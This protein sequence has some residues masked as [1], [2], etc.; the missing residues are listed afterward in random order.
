MT[1]LKHIPEEPQKMAAEKTTLPLPIF[2]AWF[3]LIFL[4]GHKDLEEVFFPFTWKPDFQCS[5]K[6]GTAFPG[7]TG[8]YCSPG[9]RHLKQV[10]QLLLTPTEA[11]AQRLCR[12]LSFTDSTS[13]LSKS[14]FDLLVMRFTDIQKPEGLKSTI[15]LCYYCSERNISI[16]HWWSDEGLILLCMSVAMLFSIKNCTDRNKVREKDTQIS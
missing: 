7:I 2:T 13:R 15:S 16:F 1:V 3:S 4:F 5:E 9:C 14:D 11:R 10:P 12:K 6:S 8:D